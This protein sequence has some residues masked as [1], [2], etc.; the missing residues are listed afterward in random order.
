MLADEAARFGAEFED[1]QSRGVV[2]KQRSSRQ[3]LDILVEAFP[4]VSGKV[5]TQNLRSRDGTDIRD[6][7]VDELH[8][9]HLEREERHRLPQVDSDILGNAQ[10][11]R[12]LTHGRS[13]GYNHEV[14]GLPSGSDAIELMVS[15]RH[16]GESLRVGGLH[17]HVVSLL[18]DGINLLEVLSHVRLRNLKEL[19]LSLLHEVVDIDGLVEGIGLN[20][21]RKLNELTGE[22]LLLEDAGM[23]FDMRR[24]RHLA[25]QFDDISRTADFLESALLLEFLGYGHDVDRLLSE[26]QSLHSLEN[27]LI[28]RLIERLG[29]DNLR[30][31][32]ERVL[33][34]HQSTEDDFLYV[35]GLR[36]EM[37]VVSVDGRLIS[38][39]W[40]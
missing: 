1:T 26:V 7:S 9:V 11:E 25:R 35:Q 34:D 3:F 17:Q 20:H 4:L 16:T 36:L 2:D 21:R 28:A 10:G 13:S 12:R 18:D 15:A 14:G 39:A 37:T 27:L 30:D 29:A 5:T 22:E 19:S 38:T 6:D 8:A 32:G 23:I 31:N 24:A 33:V 40:S